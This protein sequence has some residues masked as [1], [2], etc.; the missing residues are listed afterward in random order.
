MDKLLWH[1]NTPWSPTGYGQQTKLFTP[2]L[3]D[4]YDVAISSFYGLEGDRL[5]WEGIPVYPGLGGDWGNDYLTKNAASHFGSVRDGLL[6][7]LMDVWVLDPDMIAKMNTASW[8]PID[9]SPAPPAVK[10]FFHRSGSIPI[11]MSR[12]GQEELSEFDPLYVPHGVDTEVYKPYDK[13]ESRIALGADPDCFLVGMVAANKG[14]PS[15][16]CFSQALQ[17]FS[18]FYQDHPEAVLYLHTNMRGDEDLFSLKEA[19]GLPD[20]AVQV[21][22]QYRILLNPLPPHVMARLYS[23]FDVLLSPS[24]GEGFGIP[25]LE[26]NACGVPAIVSNFSAQKEVCGAGWKVAC[27]PR[28]TPQKSWQ[29]D[30]DVDEITAALE[31]AYNLSEDERASIRDLAVAHAAE[32]DVHKVME[33]YFLPALREIESRIDARKPVTLEAAA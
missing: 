28:W 25:V 18:D 33:D 24:A 7:T 31:S 32:Y 10:A 22:D 30:P 2:L 16:K 13:R 11:A 4:H 5:S 20:S 26:A 1:S 8:V 14:A 23:T 9:H 15:R 17:A 29:V 3:K 12:F 19:V 6:L 27:R 21:A